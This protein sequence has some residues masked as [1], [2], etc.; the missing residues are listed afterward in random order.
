MSGYWCY[1]FWR[2]LCYSSL[3]DYYCCC[4][5]A[6]SSTLLRPSSS[7]KGV[8]QHI[9]DK[10]DDW[11][12]ARD[13]EGRLQVAPDHQRMGR[14]YIPNLPLPVSP[15][16]SS[17]R[18]GGSDFSS[19][20]SPSSSSSAASTSVKSAQKSLQSVSAQLLPS[21]DPGSPYYGVVRTGDDEDDDNADDDGEEDMEITFERKVVIRPPRPASP[22]PRHDITTATA[23]VMMQTPTTATNATTTG[24][25][26][27]SDSVASDGWQRYRT[28][29]GTSAATDS[30]ANSLSNPPTTLYTPS[31][32]RGRAA[33]VLAD[34][35]SAILKEL[36]SA[37]FHNH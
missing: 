17:N 22:N 21:S 7:G 34:E 24:G 5:C 30:A 13:E 8:H 32:T 37:I 36:E 23:V 15:S 27:R 14:S 35:E 3:C 26:D 18:S 31:E 16:S 2:S 10:D 29:S 4:D 28:P 20:S 6:P 19:A 11:G 12:I 25:G 9:T 1:S 33:D